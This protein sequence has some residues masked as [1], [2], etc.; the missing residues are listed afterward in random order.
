MLDGLLGQFLAIHREHAGAA[1]AGAG[2][3]VFEVKDD[4]VLARLER[5]A[6]Q[7]LADDATDAALPAESFQIEEVVNKDR[8]AILQEQAVAAEAAAQASRSFPPRRLRER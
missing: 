2:A 5:P 1:F 7:V 6:E 4:G 8:L 3:V